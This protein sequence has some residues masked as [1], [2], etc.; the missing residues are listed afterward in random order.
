MDGKSNIL[1][2][3]NRNKKKTKKKVKDEKKKTQSRL[4]D[5]LLLTKTIFASIKTTANNLAFLALSN[6]VE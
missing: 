4:F 1:G 6:K 2:K 3:L 5:I